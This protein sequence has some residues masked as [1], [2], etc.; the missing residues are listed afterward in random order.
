MAFSLKT[1][2]FELEKNIV[3]GM[4]Q[5]N[6]SNLSSYKRRSERLA[7]ILKFQEH[8]KMHTIPVKVVKNEN[9]FHITDCVWSTE[10][11]AEGPDT[12]ECYF[13]FNEPEKY[14]IVKQLDHVVVRD[15]S[16]HHKD[17]LT[18][19]HCQRG[20]MSSLF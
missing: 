19:A 1:L 18:K 17:C 8:L 2:I 14:F 13:L 10:N 16:I 20:R 5:E 3:P 15:G 7:G 4:L 6:S 11:C 9:G 12:C